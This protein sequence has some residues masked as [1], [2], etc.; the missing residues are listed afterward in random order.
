MTHH[1]AKKKEKVY[2]AIMILITYASILMIVLPVELLAYFEN[3][4]IQRDCVMYLT[5]VF[6]VFRF[7]YIF[8]SFDFHT[9][10]YSRCLQDFLQP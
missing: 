8:S 5:M 6:C 9:L 1:L 3:V 2:L 4:F 10:L 7:K